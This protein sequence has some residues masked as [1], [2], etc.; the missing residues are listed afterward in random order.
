MTDAKQ[1]TTLQVNELLS[2][3]MIPMVNDKSVA[4]G[5]KINFISGEVKLIVSVNS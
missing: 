4:T 1:H 3:T 2:V 5:K